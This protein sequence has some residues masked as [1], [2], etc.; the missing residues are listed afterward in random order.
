[1][2]KSLVYR[3][4]EKLYRF[5]V[6]AGFEL[7]SLRNLRR[8]IKE[9]IGGSPQTVDAYVRFMFEFYFLKRDPQRPQ[10]FV[11]NSEKLFFQPEKELVVKKIPKPTVEHEFQ[12]EP[13]VLEAIEVREGE[14]SKTLVYLKDRRLKRSCSFKGYAVTW[15]A[16]R[17]RVKSL[18][19]DICYVMDA[20]QNAFLAATAQAKELIQ[21]PVPLGP[22]LLNVTLVLPYVV[23]RP[24]RRRRRYIE[25]EEEW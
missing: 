21:V 5:L 19:L 20:W 6:N 10:L 8:Y 3:R 11:V 1:M 23:E 13:G 24:R 15:G 12:P 9:Y 4:C 2:T 25:E 16:F 22:T 7:I 14:Q 18:G 17:D